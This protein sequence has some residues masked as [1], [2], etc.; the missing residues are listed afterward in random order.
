MRADDLVR[1]QTG[2]AAGALGPEVQAP[3]LWRPEELRTF[4]RL[5]ITSPLFPDI[6]GF[7]PEGAARIESVLAADT[8]YRGIEC[9]A[10]LFHLFPPPLELLR[11][12]KGFARSQLGNPEALLPQEV[13]SVLYYASMLLAYLRCHE[14]LNRLNEGALLKGLHW[15]L[16]QT[17]LNSE[18]RALFEEGTR[19][20][21]QP[22]PAQP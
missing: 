18:T 21:T 12:T 22:R 11:L 3:R 13:A 16:E 17:W 4:L 1:S 6:E 8:Y 15:G 19:R 2:Q 9:F 10:D 14:P 7:D 20:L 5:Q